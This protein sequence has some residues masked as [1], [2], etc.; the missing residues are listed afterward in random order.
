MDIIWKKIQHRFVKEKQNRAQAALRSGAI[1][2]MGAVAIAVPNLDPIISLVG[3]VF[4]SSLGLFLPAAIET[5]YLWP[6]MGK[7]YWILIKNIFLTLFALLAVVTG[8]IV[9]IQGII[10]EYVGEE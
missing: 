1:I 4:F 5:V 9:S 2:A 10:R 7:G 8:S 6:N 3:S